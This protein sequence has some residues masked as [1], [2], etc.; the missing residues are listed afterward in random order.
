MSLRS[1]LIARQLIG[2]EVLVLVGVGR[3]EPANVVKIHLWLTI[4]GGF[5]NDTYRY[6][7]IVTRL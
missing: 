3:I 1:V 7:Y 4:D 2:M 5:R 6:M